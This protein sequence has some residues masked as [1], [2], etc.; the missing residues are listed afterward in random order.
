VN[1][2]THAR[3]DHIAAV[4]ALANREAIAAAAAQIREDDLDRA[5][6]DACPADWASAGEIWPAVAKRNK[7]SERTFRRRLADLVAD[8]AL[9]SQGKGAATKYRPTG[10][11]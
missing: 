9:Y 3:L 6:L 1:E 10:L 7:V 5:I 8:G 4:L 2:D 11:V